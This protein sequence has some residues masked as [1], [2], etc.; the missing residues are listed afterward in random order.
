MFLGSSV[1]SDIGLCVNLIDG[2]SILFAIG[3]VDININCIYNM[4][5]KDIYDEKMLGFW[6]FCQ[7]RGS[8]L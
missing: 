4:Q 8:E 3:T 2:E 7:E 5:I 1:S 6:V